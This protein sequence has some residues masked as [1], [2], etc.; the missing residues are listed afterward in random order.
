[1]N[2]V[3]GFNLFCLITKSLSFNYSK[4]VTLTNA[5]WY[6]QT[7]AE[8]AEYVWSISHSYCAI[9]ATK[10]LHSLH[11]LLPKMNN[12]CANKVMSLHIFRRFLSPVPAICGTLSN[13]TLRKSMNIL[14]DELLKH[15]GTHSRWIFKSLFKNSGLCR[16]KTSHVQAVN[17]RWKCFSQL[18]SI[19]RLPWSMP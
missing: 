14:A 7:S 18:R 11:N 13:F 6:D 10:D 4:F 2:G 1:M 19:P 15:T 17:C 9:K 5:S 3:N 12:K 16:T 8:V